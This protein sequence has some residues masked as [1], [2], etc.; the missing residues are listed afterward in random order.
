MIQAA[1]LFWVRRAAAQAPSLQGM[2]GKLRSTLHCAPLWLAL[3]ACWALLGA[4]GSARAGVVAPPLA[5]AL[6]DVCRGK[7]CLAT[8]PP[9]PQALQT[10]SSRRLTRRST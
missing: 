8:L 6:V 7:P 5:A 9:V 10:R 4:V 3:S 2:N 1:S